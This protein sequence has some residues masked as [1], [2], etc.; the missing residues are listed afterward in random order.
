M[1]TGER[2]QRRHCGIPNSIALG[3][4]LLSRL[5]SNPGIQSPEPPL[6]LVRTPPAAIFALGELRSPAPRSPPALQA[7]HLLAELLRRRAT[8]E[9]LRHQATAELLR[10]R[11]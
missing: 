11:A 6:I 4:S 5:L 3:L 2:V 9:L 8:A 7:V 1:R 10:R